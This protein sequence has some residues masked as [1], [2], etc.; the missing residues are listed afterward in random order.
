MVFNEVFLDQVLACS[1]FVS[2]LPF[3]E[4]VDYVEKGSLD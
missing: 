1:F 3:I 4:D 2:D